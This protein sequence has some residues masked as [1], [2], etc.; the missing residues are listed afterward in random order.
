M[1]NDSKLSSIEHNL[2]PLQCNESPLAKYL[3]NIEPLPL[4]QRYPQLKHITNSKHAYVTVTCVFCGS[5]FKATMYRR[6]YCS[7][8]CKNDAWIIRRREYAKQKR[9]KVC[10]FCKTPFKAKSAKAKFCCLKH[11]VANFRKKN[12]KELQQ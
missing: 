1:S 8:R 12:L 3:G 5:Q 2:K 4:G 9:N 6:K 11:R 10:Q 7:Y